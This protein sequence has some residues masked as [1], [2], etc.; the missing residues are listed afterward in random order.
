[1]VAE[2]ADIEFSV[3]R[4]GFL[5]RAMGWV[6]EQLKAERE[7]WSLWLPVILASGV[8]VYFGL[9]VEPP[10]WLGVSGIVAALILAFL[11]RRAPGGLILAFAFGAFCLAFAAGQLRTYQVSAPVIEKRIG[12]VAITGQVLRS[13]PRP[14]GK[15]RRLLLH[16]LAIRSVP[17]AQTPEKIR[18]SVLSAADDLNPGDWIR[19]RAILQPPPQP[20]VPGAFDFARQAYFQQLGAVGYA[21]SRVT[22]NTPDEDDVDLSS[23]DPF[24]GWA[25][26]WAKL[27]HNIGQRVMTALPGERGA[28][29]AALI[30]G[31]RGAIPEPLL[32]ALR[33]A[34]LAHLLAISGLHIGLVAGLLFF[35]VR[36]VLALI[37]PLA[38]NY[39]IKKWAAVLAG[40]GA[41]TYLLLVGAPVPTQRA[42][43]MIAVVLLAVA[44]DR[45]AVSLRLVA[46]A[47]SVILIFA[48][49]S[50]LS[51]SFQMSFAAVTA[52]VA[53]YELF[54]AYRARRTGARGPFSRVG[55]Y[56]G[57]VTLSSVIAGLATAPF[58]IYH[59]NRIAW[60]GLAANLIAVPVTALWIMPWAIAAV[61][62]L[63]FGAEE[64]A[65]IPM[66]WGIEVVIQV[67]H[68][69]AAW[70]GAVT[71]VPAMPL[72]GLLLVALGGAWLCL[73]RRSWRLGGLV[74]M[75]L[76]LATIPLMSLPDVLIDGNG[77]LFAARSADGALR[78]SS[79]S[80]AKFE[81]KL[82]LRR[83]G[84][85][86][87]AATLMKAGLDAPEIACD[88]LGCIYRRTGQ[89][90]ALI[91]DE[92]ALAE[93]CLSATVV[94]AR[95][96]V[97][98]N[99]R[100]PEVVID[101][102]DLW[103][104]GAHAIWLSPKT[105]RVETVSA[106]RG[107]RPWVVRREQ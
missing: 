88:A 77:K 38:L 103:R 31:E 8:A 75:V 52:L 46:W 81:G 58:A 39:P 43:L 29:A 11:F 47:A 91:T 1:M 16:R 21:V 33:D 4:P 67:A 49:E 9:P 45:N 63:P 6:W 86:N 55:L 73:W 42:F 12:P 102:F 25:L 34:G 26:W 106:Y 61:L 30:T 101:R 95:V 3:R 37:P 59:F 85:N 76:G 27:R 100:Q 56:L 84:Q 78:L 51:A 19:L 2:I 5:F 72:F 89:V 22:L 65:L 79:K 44:L 17:V 68:A 7:S 18:I 94:V 83:D 69:V 41:F 13:E 54:A 62:L 32:Q 80:Q 64:L 87:Q 48:P 20:A 57:T 15:G 104:E 99:C 90:V 35:A 10:L 71:L 66:A 74:S 14:T 105:I 98:R 23:A 53:G 92:R 82:W 60:F 97:R 28:V 93:D 96:P 50:L 40:C 107:R 24:T 36:A 70:P